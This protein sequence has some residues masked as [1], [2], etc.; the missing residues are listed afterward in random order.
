M[1][2]FLFLVVIIVGWALVGSVLK[3]L[4]EEGQ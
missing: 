3:D 2:T 1:M 4:I